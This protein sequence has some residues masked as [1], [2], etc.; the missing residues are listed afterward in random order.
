V[1]TN[2]SQKR[3][4]SIFCNMSRILSVPLEPGSVDTSQHCWT[5]SCA[6]FGL[7]V[8]V[9]D[10][11]SPIFGWERTGAVEVPS[12][13]RQRSGLQPKHRQVEHGTSGEH[14]EWFVADGADPPARPTRLLRSAGGGG[15]F[16][17]YHAALTAA[18]RRY[19][20]SLRSAF[21]RLNSIRCSI[22]P[23]GCFS[24][25]PGVLIG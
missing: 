25:L 3:N 24:P 6:W 1:T 22:T 19:R 14:G 16:V 9:T 20:P 21:T 18:R 12:N 8:C 10:P 13:I 5:C 4:A 17:T 2:H 11:L 15:W 23:I 7:C